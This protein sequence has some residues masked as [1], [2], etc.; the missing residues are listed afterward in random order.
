MIPSILWRVVAVARCALTILGALWRSS[1]DWDGVLDY[2]RLADL[3]FD[4][5]PVR[6]EDGGPLPIRM[7]WGE[8]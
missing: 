1:R 6:D 5:W 2:Y 8:R 3:I 7:P 4:A